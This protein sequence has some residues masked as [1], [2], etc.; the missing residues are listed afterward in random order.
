MAMTKDS[1]SLAY[2]LLLGAANLHA[3]G[4]VI[5]IP[6]EVPEYEIP[7]KSVEEGQIVPIAEEGIDE[8]YEIPS[9]SLGEDQVVPVAEEGIDESEDFSVP[10]ETDEDTLASEF[11]LFK[12]LMQDG[13]LDEADSVAKRVVE[14]AIRSKGPQSSEFAKALTNLAIVQYQT[15]QYDAAQQNFESAIEII[16]D[17]EDRLNAQL[18]NPLRGL[19]ASQ[20][21]SGRPD[22]A[23]TSFQRAVH[24]THVNEGP[25]NLDQ[26]DLLESLSETHIRMGDLDAAKEE[27][28]HIHALN[29]R[30]YGLDTLALVPSLMSRADWQERAG[31]I[32]DERTTYRRIVRIIEGNAGKKDLQLVE[33][34]IRLGRSFFYV[35]T[36]GTES[37]QQ[38]RMS[39]GEIYFRRAA[40]IAEES[41]DSNWQVTAQATLALGD[42]Y[43]YDNN[44]QRGRRVYRDAWDL[45]S[46]GEDRLDV[47][48]IQLEGVIPLRQRKLPQY[49]N[50]SDKDA[51]MQS[52]DPLL[53]GRVVMTYV[54]STRGRADELKMVEAEP[55]EFTKMQA[56]VQRE[57]RRRIYRPRFADAEAIVT[58]DQLLVHKFFYRQSDL[59]AVIAAT[60]AAAD[61]GK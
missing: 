1:I 14:L 24:V 48:R 11:V 25:H 13:V 19:G 16:E 3:E 42:Y 45:L 7:P 8:V 51:G 22:L 36:S 2:L 23:K 33:P 47:R 26:V 32:Y 60:A 28:D 40:R 38:N 46:E 41:P 30:E 44:P 56:H 58:P 4:N 55:A 52:D 49:I 29:I 50:S 57:M 18:V 17:I 61:K 5:N 43:M 9:E 31:F 59:D 12:Q 34:L 27:Q 39:T 35:D 53:Q 54:V 37:F 10:E 15:K 20:L 6:A 21:E